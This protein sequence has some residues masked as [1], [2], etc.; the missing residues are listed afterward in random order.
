MLYPVLWPY[1]T[2][3][4]TA[5]GFTPFQLVYGLEFMFPVACKI[6]SLSLVVE[7]LP[8]TS[9]LKQ[10]L[11]HLE[12]LDEQRWDVAIINE[13]NQ[14]RVKT[15]YD[16]VV[17]PR[18]FSEGDLVLVYDQEKDALGAGK[19]KPIWYGPFI[20]K[21]VLEKAT[22]E[23]VNFEGNKLEEPRNG[24]YVKKYFA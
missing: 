12:H 2:S 10:R 21:R 23:L 4:K 20:I 14:K 15:Q 6:P 1:Q 16:K 7:L 8:E 5:T 13:A 3:V 19:F 9:N 22:Y 11:L 17:R 24:L 18:V